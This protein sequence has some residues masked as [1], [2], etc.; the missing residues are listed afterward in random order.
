MFYDQA[1]V[2]R[3]KLEEKIQSLQLQLKELPEGKLTCSSNGKYCKWYQSDGHEQIYI[4]KKERQL[5]EQLAYKK[6]LSLQLKNALQE[7]CAMDFYFRHHNM[8]AVHE[9][10]SFI[11]SPKY[12]ELL[13]SSFTP[14]S[15][16]LAMWQNSPYTKN[17]KHP[18]NLIHKAASGNYVRSKSEAMIDMCLVKY[19]I[20]F[21]YEA[22]LQL[23]EIVVF[24]DYTLRHPETGRYSYWENFGLMDDPNYSKNAGSKLQFYISNGII[25]SIHLITTFE[26]KDNPLT[27]DTIENILRDFLNLR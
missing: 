24:P 11:N 6:Y 10:Q 15:Q 25:P 12:K 27:F 18:E 20:P 19:R 26:T 22:A 7:L 1:V 3:Q 21:R 9:E 5:A 2:Q 17:N 23:G 4:P 8:D 16:E 14:L 13:S